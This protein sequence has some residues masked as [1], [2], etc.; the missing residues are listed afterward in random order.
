ME[1]HTGVIFSLVICALIMAIGIPGNCLI[2]RVFW[3]KKRKTSTRIL[4][5]SLAW[6]DLFSC[7]LLAS[8]IGEFTSTLAGETLPKA[9]GVLN[10]LLVT[11]ISTSVTLT[12]VVAF[13][14]YDC[15]CRPHKR[16]LNEK[17]IKIAFCCSI[18]YSAALSIPYLIQ[19]MLNCNSSE[20]LTLVILTLQMFCYATALSMIV[21]CYSKVYW[22]IR[23]RVKIGVWSSSTKDNLRSNENTQRYSQHTLQTESNTALE[24]V[25]AIPPDSSKYT[26]CSKFAWIRTGTTAT[27]RSLCRKSDAA[28]KVVRQT[29]K[30]KSGREGRRCRCRSVSATQDNAHAAFDQYSFYDTLASILDIRCSAVYPEC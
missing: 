4:I 25:S 21:L 10:V 19:I 1:G 30:P 17:R 13:D 27:F 8:R 6:T 20:N 16:L 22:T 11:T 24:M 15:V 26:R 3:L 7:F 5:L 12:A 9:L 18:I 23:Q 28:R 14:R 29:A 2:L